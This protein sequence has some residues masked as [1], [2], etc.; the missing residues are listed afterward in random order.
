MAILWFI[1]SLWKFYW[2]CS[3]WKY[4]CSTSLVS[5]LDIKSSQWE[6]IQ[7]SPLEMKERI[8]MLVLCLKDNY[9][10]RP[11][12]YIPRLGGMT[13]RTESA[14]KDLLNMSWEHVK[15]STPWIK[16]NV[17]KGT[18]CWGKGKW[19][20]RLWCSAVPR[21]LCLAALERRASYAT[22]NHPPFP[23]HEKR[24]KSTFN[25]ASENVERKTVTIYDFI[26]KYWE[27]LHFRGVNVICQ[28]LNIF[29][30]SF[31]F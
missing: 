2:N 3:S 22:S 7:N 28:V 6:D 11:A 8:K 31:T 1:T 15:R 21:Y 29:S 26:K 14:A 13:S 23:L 19:K 27:H 5:K 18:V 20:A 30:P 24:W 10:A 12:P 9:T 16:R 17:S 4:N 25:F